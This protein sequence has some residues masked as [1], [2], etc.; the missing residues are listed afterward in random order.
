[1]GNSVNSGISKDKYLGTPFILKLPTIDIITDQVRALG[2]GCMLYKINIS[3]AFR[4]IK[5]DPIDYDLSG[6]CHERH[7]IDTCLPFGY[8][9]GSA[10]F[11][12]IS[13]AVCHMMCQCQFDVIN[14]IDDILG[15]DI[16]S[17]I[18]ASFDALCHLLHALGFEISV[19]ELEKPATLL[20]CLGIIVDTRNF[21]LSIPPQKCKKYW[22]YVGLGIIGLTVPNANFNLF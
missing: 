4:H 13:D 22:T 1:M 14:Y 9:N 7:Y 5:L 2:R 21:T 15:I 16:P 18:D 8:R 3:R 6:L 19:K 10:I 12:R 20:N 11:Q 17:K